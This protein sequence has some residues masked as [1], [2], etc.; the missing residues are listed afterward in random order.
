M[1]S[2]TANETTNHFIRQAFDT[3]DLDETMRTVLLTPSRELRVELIITKDDG[4]IGHYIG[5]RVQH[6]DTL[7]PYKGG[8]R[9]HPAVDVDHVRSLASLMTWKTALIGVPFGGGKGGIQVDPNELSE[10]ELERLTRRFVDAIHE[11]IG[12]VTDIPAPD[13]NTNARVM[14]WIFDHY[15]RYHG[16][17]PAVVTGKPVDLHGSVGRDAATGRGCMFA[18]REVLAH[19]NKTIA[20]QRVAI[21]GF[22]NVGSWGARLLHAEGAKIVAV[23]D[24][25]GAIHNADGLD[26][27]A[28]MQHVAK[29]KTVVGFAGAEMIDNDQLLTCD[30]DVLMPAAI[31]HVLTEGNARD[32]KASY[33]LEGANG[34]TTVEADAI[35]NERGI[36]TIPDIYANAG[37]VTVSYFEWTQNT[38][39]LRWDEEQVNNRLDQHM[40]AAHKAIRATMAAHNIPMRQAAFVTAVKRVL[41]GTEARGLQ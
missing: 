14:G 27:P 40:I 21:Q 32:V 38:Q 9:Y 10:R 17:S 7:G 37:G 18:L 31:G 11:F 4:S 39:Q 29:K 25:H 3:L 33:I 5:Y 24:V 26:I 1:S 12:P 2:R 41:A 15:S 23:S 8:L 6:D 16:F 34:P 20:G 19:D 13:M 35:F 30:C 22:G 28:L 36:T